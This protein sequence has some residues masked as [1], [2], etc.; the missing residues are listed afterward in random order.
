[1]AHRRPSAT[2]P[3]EKQP[4][5]FTFTLKALLSLPYRLCN[6]PPAVGK[7]RSCQVTPL[8][9][10]RLEDV[11]N[12]KHL[13]PLGLKDFEE[14]LLFV[15]GCPENLH[16]LPPPFFTRPSLTFLPSSY[17]MLWLKEYAVRYNQWVAQ[18]RPPKPDAQYSSRD[19]YRFS[20][21]ALPSNA[22]AHFY[23][24]AKQTFFTPGGDYELNIPSD[25]LTPFHTGHFVSPHPDP[26]VFS[27]L[28]WQVHHMLKESL[29]RFVLAAYNNVG[30]NR[31]LCGTVGGT[32][33]ALAGSVPPIVVNF[34]H[35][36]SRWLRL[37]AL[38]GLWL[39]LT[40]VL[41]SLHGV[42]MMVYIFGDLRQLRKFELARPSISAPQPLGFPPARPQI[43]SPIVA[44]KSPESSTSVLPPYA[45][46]RP[47]Q[48]PS[49]PLPSKPERPIVAIPSTAHL[50]PSESRF[51]VSPST[52]YDRSSLT[53]ATYSSSSSASVS[54]FSSTSHQVDSDPEALQIMISPAYYDD[55]PAPEG[56]NTHTG[57]WPPPALS[58][59]YLRPNPNFRFGAPYEHS[60]ECK[61]HRTHGTAGF[62][63]PYDDDSM[64]AFGEGK[65][66]E[67]GP[68][69]ASGEFDFDALPLRNE[70][71]QCICRPQLPAIASSVALPMGEK[72]A[73]GDAPP[74]SPSSSAGSSP[75]DARMGRT[76]YRCNEPPVPS[77]APARK[78]HCQ[79]GR[80]DVVTQ[81]WAWVRSVPAFGPV[82]KVLSPVVTRAQWEIVVRSAALAAMISF[83]VVFGLVGAPVMH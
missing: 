17:F 31:A 46:T 56:P 16:V 7:V 3:P 77:S 36:H 43:S 78:P 50:R 37:L 65:A 53:S 79:R 25:I 54:G 33:I 32:V 19:E 14:W 27:D 4:R 41:A 83:A 23:L 71:A 40:I 48:P 13:P 75:V 38:P 66:L 49:A 58:P 34:M 20:T 61:F 76:Q 82:T 30:T 70:E 1:M 59:G 24:R 69:I 35:G 44:Y 55:D 63:Y 73:E 9:K 22:L 74:A 29:D 21:Q 15:E 72:A 11:L 39:G 57:P 10:V 18:N 2:S 6:P 64:H 51:P 80:P 28:A 5:T 60:P 45:F 47:R 12:K 42:C 52:P 8:F 26:L 62:I 67:N 68:S 81:R